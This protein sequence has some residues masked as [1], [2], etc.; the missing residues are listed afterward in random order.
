MR[1]HCYTEARQ[2]MGKDAGDPPGCRPR[3]EKCQST[4]GE[5]GISRTRTPGP[6]VRGSDAAAPGRV[7][8]S[9]VPF[10]T[11]EA[12]AHPDANVRTH[13][14]MSMQIHSRLTRN[15][16]RYQAWSRTALVQSAR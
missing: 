2:W 6:T 16:A 11:S 7:A 13:S 5:R 10:A 8:D 15:A 3:L 4:A 1:S 12:A 9:R 14:M